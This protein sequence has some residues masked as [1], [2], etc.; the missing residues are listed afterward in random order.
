MS[1]FSLAGRFYTEF[2]LQPGTWQAD[3]D[4]EF[5]QGLAAARPGCSR[6]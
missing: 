2:G 5:P 3:E 4:L 6:E 1:V